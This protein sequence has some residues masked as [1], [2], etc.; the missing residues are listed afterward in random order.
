M[1]KID[2]RREALCAYSNRSFVSLVFYR[3]MKTPLRTISLSAVSEA[4]VHN[5]RNSRSSLVGASDTALRLI[6]IDL[7]LIPTGLV[8]G[9][10]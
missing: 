4:P 8:F 6:V 9:C 10:M 5:A 2:I 1:V 3:V 7:V